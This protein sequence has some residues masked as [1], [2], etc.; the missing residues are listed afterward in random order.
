MKY[1]LTLAVLFGISGVA[2]AAKDQSA[3]ED[4]K[5]SFEKK[6]DGSVLRVGPSPAS[7]VQG[8]CR[9]VVLSRSG[10]ELFQVQGRL[11]RLDSASSDLNGDGVR[12][13]AFQVD[14]APRDVCC[15]VYYVLSF[16]DSPKLLRKIEDGQFFSLEDRDNDKAPEVWAADA[17]AFQNFDGLAPRELTVLPTVVF[18]LEGEKLIDAGPQFQID[19][20]ILIG[21]LSAQL[22]ADRAKDFL[23]S[24]GK[25]T[26]PPD[27]IDPR[28]RETK[29]LV[30]GMVW[31]YLY[32]GR[33]QEAWK[34]LAELWP[35]ADR[36]RI[37][38]LIQEKRAHGILAKVDAAAPVRP[39]GCGPPEVAS[40]TLE[41]VTGPAGK[42][43]IAA[44]RAI[45]TP[46][47]NYSPEASKAK[48]EG[49]VVLWVIVGPD[50]CAHNIRVQ[51]SL[52]KGLD[53]KAIEAVRQWKFRPAT[54]NGVPVA[55]QVNIEIN[56]RLH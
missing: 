9:L 36:D 3:C 54:K 46:D 1:L 13:A 40:Q 12:D 35:A 31:D 2:L 4:G 53:E 44:P 28:L 51:R 45:S 17:K 39:W 47:P 25:L 15:S 52:G 55:V 42:Y 29:M 23:A 33:E 26:G 11:I 37:R 16:G 5:G 56:F 48:L 41:K 10:A 19:Y 6:V 38:S 30:L 24:D 34:T 50:G 22:T 8:S 20:D 7:E 43:V 21:R 49:T 14:F 18:R 27:T 32:S